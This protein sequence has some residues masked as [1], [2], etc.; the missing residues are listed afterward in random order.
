M[1]V[2]ALVKMIPLGDSLLS[3]YPPYNDALYLVRC[4]DNIPLYRTEFSPNPLPLAPCIG[5]N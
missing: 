5:L 3:R 4:T 2:N 1:I